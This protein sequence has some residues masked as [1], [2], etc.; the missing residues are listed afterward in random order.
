VSDIIS[1][2]LPGRVKILKKKLITMP[3][4]TN[5]SSKLSQYTASRQVLL[6]EIG[7]FLRNE[8]LYCNM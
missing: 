5:A 3:C 2:Y 7:F 4:L 1:T 6:R 8:Y